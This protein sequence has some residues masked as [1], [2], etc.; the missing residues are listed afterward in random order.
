MVSKNNFVGGLKCKIKDKSFERP[1]VMKSLWESDYRY[2]RP[3]AECPNMMYPKRRMPV[4]CSVAFWDVIERVHQSGVA[5]G[6][7]SM[8]A[9]REPVHALMTLLVACISTQARLIFTGNKGPLKLLHVNEYNLDKSFIYAMVVLSK[10]M[11]EHGF[12]CGLFGEWPP[13]LPDSAHSQVVP[14]AYIEPCDRVS[15][16]S[17]SK[18]S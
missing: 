2:S 17:S 14:I 9:T 5:D 4:R 11:G 8:G 16:A 7:V 10:I 3:W 12:P 18:A 1:I 15:V 6:G 13:P